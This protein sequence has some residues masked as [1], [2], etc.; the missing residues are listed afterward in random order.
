MQTRVFIRAGLAA[1]LLLAALFGAYLYLRARAIDRESYERLEVGMTR[2]EVEDLLGGPPCNRLAEPCDVWVPSPAG[3]RSA[4]LQPGTPNVRF[5]PELAGGES[6]AVW[7]GEDGLIA[8][9][10]DEDGRL[11]EKYFSEVVV[12]EGPWRPARAFFLPSGK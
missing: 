11:R 1:A 2:A 9:R 10:F 4:D 7:V 3:L 6:E 12:P 8:L 5:F